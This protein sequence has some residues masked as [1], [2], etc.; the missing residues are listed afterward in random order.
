[1]EVDLQLKRIDLTTIYYSVVVV[2]ELIGHGPLYVDVI[3]MVGN[4]IRIAWR[5][6]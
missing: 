1:M 2:H 6:H 4:V 3:E 5:K